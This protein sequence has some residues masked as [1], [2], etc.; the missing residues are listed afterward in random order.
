M[1]KL[2]LTLYALFFI[3]PLTGKEF[4]LSLL[5][6]QSNMDGSGKVAELTDAQKEPFSVSADLLCSSVTG[7][8]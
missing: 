6:G 2:F 1:K 5:A 7:I 4:D 3:L 8:H